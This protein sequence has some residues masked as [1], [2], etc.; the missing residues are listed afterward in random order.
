MSVFSP[1]YSSSKT[2]LIGNL[3]T[4]NKLQNLPILR[5][6]P[7]SS[8]FQS[9]AIWIIYMLNN[10]FINKQIKKRLR[11]EANRAEPNKSDHNDMK[12]CWLLCH[13]PDKP[14]HPIH[15]VGS[16]AVNH[17]SADCVSTICLKLGVKFTDCPPA[18]QE[19]THPKKKTV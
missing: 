18:K 17:K 11:L 9:D 5:T 13:N 10:N 3:A 6:R 2:K 4:F 12:I 15:T 7:S 16:I 8:T 1:L 19:R 14:I